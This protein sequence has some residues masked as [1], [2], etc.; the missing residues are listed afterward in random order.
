M[1]QRTGPTD[2][3]EMLVLMPVL[4][5]RVSDASHELALKC[6][7]K[8]DINASPMMRPQEF[9]EVNPRRNAVRGKG[10]RN[11]RPQARSKVLG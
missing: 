6:A 7:G 4:G 8:A 1:Y 11:C 5:P 2:F 10:S 9:N 3:D